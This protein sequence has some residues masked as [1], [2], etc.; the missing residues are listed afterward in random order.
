R[1][2][3]AGIVRRE[4]TKPIIAAVEGPALAG[5]FEIVLACDLVVAGSNARFGIPEVKRSLIANAGGLIRLPRA[6]PRNLA[7]EMA[8]TG[9][10]ISAETAHHHGVVNRLV[11]AGGALDSAIALASEISAN[12]PL[13]VR[14]SRQVIIEGALLDDDEAFALSAEAA[15]DVLR[16]EDFQEGPRAFIEKRAPNWLGR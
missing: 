12:A 15:R 2:G 6:I 4:R 16:S 11:E 5:G 14:A 3:F 13:A 10:P 9:D 7:M 8:L 1:G